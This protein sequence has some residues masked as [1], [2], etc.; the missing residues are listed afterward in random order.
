MRGQSRKP[1]G[2]L[3]PT[4]FLSFPLLP[5]DL[6]VCFTSS[7]PFCTATRAFY[8]RSEVSFS[9]LLFQSPDRQD[10]ME[11]V[12]SNT[13]AI[14]Y[15]VARIHANCDDVARPD[16]SLIWSICSH[17][18]HPQVLRLWN[19]RVTLFYCWSKFQLNDQSRI[20][21]SLLKHSFY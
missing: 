3:H 14:L 9:K 5:Q 18:T 19:D 6:L 8:R 1:P 15:R 13:S 12:S 16:D 11:R 17:K 20:I 4:L 7:S 2:C 21:P 10:C